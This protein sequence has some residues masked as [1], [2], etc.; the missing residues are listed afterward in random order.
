VKEFLR[1]RPLE[2]WPDIPLLPCRTITVFQQYSDAVRIRLDAHNHLYHE[3]GQLVPNLERCGVEI[4]G[5]RQDLGV[6]PTYLAAAQ[7]AI[8]AIS[9]YIDSIGWN[10]RTMKYAEIFWLRKKPMA[11]QRG[12]DWRVPAHVRDAIRHGSEN[13]RRRVP[14][15]DEACKRLAAITI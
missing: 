11:D 6:I 4:D 7:R 1:L 3:G 8:A 15:S 2:L 9:R 5:E 12:R 13:V 10:D 14:L